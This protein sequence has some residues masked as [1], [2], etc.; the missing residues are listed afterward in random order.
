MHTNLFCLT[1]ACVRKGSHPGILLALPLPGPAL[2]PEEPAEVLPPPA[3]SPPSL[4]RHRDFVENRRTSPYIPW[5]LPFWIL[6]VP[7]G[8]T[9]HFVLE[10]FGWLSVTNFCLSNQM[11]IPWASY[12]FRTEDPVRMKGQRGSQVQPHFINKEAEAGR[13]RDLLRDTQV[14]PLPALVIDLGGSSTYEGRTIFPGVSGPASQQQSQQPWL[15][16]SCMSSAPK[17]GAAPPWGLKEV[18]TQRRQLLTWWKSQGHGL[19]MVNQPISLA[20]CVSN[21]RVMPGGDLN[22]YYSGSPLLENERNL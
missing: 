6:S 2:T 3:S 14:S 8:N 20:I 1:W 9:L 12:T 17:R 22:F 18:Y 15:R 21:V 19:L 10:F 4:L 11:T 16:V 13:E 7:P 5:H